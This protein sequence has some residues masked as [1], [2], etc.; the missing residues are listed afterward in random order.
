MTIS[1][2]SVFEPQRIRGVEMPWNRVLR[3]AADTVAGAA[4]ALGPWHPQEFLA[5]CVETELEAGDMMTFVF[6]RIDGAPLAFRAGQYLNIAFPVSGVDGEPVDRSYSLSSSPTQPWTFSITVK[7]D[8]HVSQWAHEHVKP[9]VVLDML[10]P[11]G[12]FHLPDF[13]R[14]AR[15]LFLAAGSGITPLM[16]ML[17]TIHSLPGKANVVLLYHA[18]EPGGFAFSRELEYLRSVDSR[19]RVYYSLGDRG[20][21]GP[22]E[23]MVGRLTADM[24]EQVTPDVSGR[25]VYACG[26]EGYLDAA[27][28]LLRGLNVAD[29]QIHQEFF[30]GDRQTVL[31]Y[32]E[33]IAMAEEIAGEV[34]ASGEE[35]YAQQPAAL[36]MYAQRDA[37]AEGPPNSGFEDALAGPPSSG[38]EAAAE[39]GKPPPSGFGERPAGPPSSGFGERP[40]GPPASGFPMQTESTNATAPFD[41]IA[42]PDR[43]AKR[44][45]THGD[46]DRAVFSEPTEETSSSAYDTLSF[47]TVGEGTYKISFMRSQLNVMVSPDEPILQ[48]ARR[49]GV[50]IGMNC[51]EGMCGSCKSVKLEGDVDMNHQGGIRA[52]EIDAGKF[53]PCC[54]TA[55]SDVVVDA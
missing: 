37:S 34:A 25:E 44:G 7:R 53:L 10:G 39:T 50:R 36:D 45:E 41:R 5:E 46:A 28:E 15:Y 14:R 48:A 49:A 9:G 17:R 19:V 11:V 23:G 47:K 38:F 6:R 20:T 55:K 12:A 2:S 13:D 26:P 4:R 33:E 43:A 16:S 21:S 27:A 52:R 31:E 22:W 1:S 35:Y 40:A 54:S 51:Q 3:A 42:K 18:A 24:I 8:G 30:T 29:T 32:E